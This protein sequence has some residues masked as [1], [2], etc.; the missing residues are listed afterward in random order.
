MIRRRTP[1]YN[2]RF[3]KHGKY[4][5]SF[6]AISLITVAAFLY[7]KTEQ[8]KHRDSILK[9][10][11]SLISEDIDFSRS[12]IFFSES[13][14]L[15][16]QALVKNTHKIQKLL[17]IIQNDSE[18]TPKLNASLKQL[19]QT[20]TNLNHLINEF[21]PLFIQ[22][23]QGN[24]QFHKEVDQCRNHLNSPKQN[25]ALSNLISAHNLSNL[26]IKS[27]ALKHF[28]TTITQFEANVSNDACRS[29]AIQSKQLITLQQKLSKIYHQ[30]LVLPLKKDTLNLHT[31]YQQAT[32]NDIQNNFWYNLALVIIS[33]LFLTFITLSLYRLFHA[34]LNLVNTLE[35]LEQQKDIYHALSEANHAVTTL[36]DKKEIYQA[37]TDIIIRYIRIP[38]CWIAEKEPHSDW[39]VPTAISGIGKEILSKVQVS[40]DANKPEGQGGVGL[41]YRSKK[42]IIQNEYA[43]TESSRPWFKEAVKW[44]VRSL[45]SFPIMRE[46]EVEAV[47]VFYALTPNFFN[48]K[49]VKIIQELIDDVGLGLERLQFREIE[50]AHQA[51]QTISAIAFESQESIIITDERRKILKTN[52]AFTE[53]TGY[54]ENEVLGLKPDILRSPKHPTQFYVDSWKMVEQTG[55]WKGEAWSQRKDGTDYQV[56]QTIT[57]VFDDKQTITNY[58][59]HRIDITQSKQAESEISYLKNHDDLT[60]LAN[61]FFLKQKIEQLL[62][63]EQRGS[64][65]FNFILV[66]VNIKRFKMLNETLGHLAGDE[67]LVET[68]NRLK[69]IQ[70]KDSIN[71]SI[72]RI[73][74]D[75]FTVLCQLNNNK[76]ADLNLQASQVMNAINQRFD[77]PYQLENEQVN[78]Q[79]SLGVTLFDTQSQNTPEELIQQALTALN[80]ARKS[81]K[82]NFEFY[83]TEMQERAIQE[84][85]LEIALSKALD[86]EEFVLYYQ[87]QVCLKTGKVIGAEVLVRWQKPDG[88]LI[89][90]LEFIPTLESTSLIIP[91]GYWLIQQALSDVQPYQSKFK[92]P[93]LIAIN[94]SAIQFKDPSLADFIENTITKN[95][96]NPECLELE[97]TESILMENPEAVTEILEKLSK[98]GTKIAIDDFGTGYSSLAYI[99]H[100]PVNKLKIDKSFIDDIEKPK[101]YAI[102][103]SIIE[104]AN[105]MDIR[106]IAE[107]VETVAQKEM[108]EQLNCQE[109]QGYFYSQP[110][111]F[112]EFIQ[113]ALN[114][115]LN[116]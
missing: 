29:L 16:S 82:N 22:Y 71:T 36:T 86:N 44:G 101:D 68:A 54:T 45:A 10:A 27:E 24:N 23:A 109:V 108:L 111:P 38:S 93:L 42:A 39:V 25:I 91:L 7:H 26:P 97:V 78:I 1:F 79:T 102:V 83:Q 63:Q 46:G 11:I 58:I 56:Y 31:L 74:S 96:C 28:S 89:P 32:N 69:N 34:N 57:A 62:L 81:D 98:H 15:D 85:N 70:L 6:F 55:R 52:Q 41:A 113:Y 80:R 95:N 53:M 84:R 73:G 35:D 14:Q 92:E 5:I 30:I 99:K 59:L 105:A 100:F 114:S 9:N 104:M 94:L 60:G 12:M 90:P 21:N 37:I 20:V 47:I 48:K 64:V 51:S 40:I 67:I 87:P 33:L 8:I 2:D 72:S 17:R 103:R 50:K 77:L 116:N 112:D 49:I 110:L 106:S 115:N 13:Q 61:R 107:G 66:I 65:V 43:L 75:E 18:D 88:T 76:N 4:V 3:I 19:K